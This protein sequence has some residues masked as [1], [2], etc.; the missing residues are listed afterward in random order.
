[1][2]IRELWFGSERMNMKLTAAQ[3]PRLEKSGCGVAQPC[4]MGPCRVEN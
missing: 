1:M 3:K 2:R 4:F